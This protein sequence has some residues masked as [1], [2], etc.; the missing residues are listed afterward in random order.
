MTKTIL[1]TAIIATTFIILATSSNAYA[2][3]S[4]F[5]W[6][7][8]ISWT[9]P[10]TGGE[11]FT[12]DAATKTISQITTGGFNR[13]DDVEI[14]PIASTLYWNNWASG[15]ANSSPTEGIY[16]SNLDGTAQIQVTGVAES[17][18]SATGAA[19][20]HGISLDPA[21]Q[22]IFFTR[23]VSYANGNGLGEVS[24]VN[25]DGTGY[26]KLD[27]PNDSWFPSGIALDSNT[28]TVYWGSPGII[29]V[30]YNGAV[31]SMDTSG[32][33]KTVLVPHGSGQGRSLALDA[34]NGLIF[35]SSWT[36]LNP[37]TGG[38]IWVYNVT[39]GIASNVLNTPTNGIPDIELD[40]ANMRIYWT[41]FTNGQIQSADYDL[42]GNLSNISTE[43]SGLTNPFGLA[44]VFNNAP[45]CTNSVAS[46]ELLWPPNHKMNNITIQGIVDADGDAINIIIDSITQDEALNAKGNGDGNTSPDAAGVGAD[47]AQIRAERAGN[48]DGR[49]YEISFTADD[50]NGGI[51]SGSVTVG[52]PHDKKDTPIDNGQTVDSTGP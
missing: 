32:G 11:I 36:P 4:D 31:N 39:S 21:N 19:G 2:T 15:P 47:T 5:Y 23:G 50:G 14:D 12:A 10:G 13:I 52:V 37:L 18:S 30:P 6:S 8:T 44:L 51:C 46:T 28:N 25:M 38:G 40:S 16:A 26:S 45:D 20:L 24:V 29:G 41:E 27:A 1:S 35:Y 48:G 17:S 43:I 34:G 22:K 33:S 3:V 42:N 9:A 49:V 7:E